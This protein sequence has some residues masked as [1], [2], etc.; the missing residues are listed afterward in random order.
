MRMRW[1]DGLEAPL[2]RYRI[3][4][5]LLGLGVLL[6]VTAVVVGLKLCCAPLP[7]AIVKPLAA[8]DPAVMEEQ[9]LR[10]AVLR[11]A[12]AMSKLNAARAKAVADAVN[13]RSNEA[14]P[15]S[16]LIALNS[17]LALLRQLDE[18]LRQDAVADELAAAAA[19]RGVSAGQM[20]VRNSAKQ[21]LAA[22]VDAKKPPYL[23]LHLD[24]LAPKRAPGKDFIDAQLKVASRAATT[25]QWLS[26]VGS[27]A[28]GQ[29]LNDSHMDAFQ[30]GVIEGKP[31]RFTGKML[32]YNHSLE[33]RYLMS[34]APSP[35]DPRGFILAS[36]TKCPDRVDKTTTEITID[37]LLSTSEA[38][39]RLD[40]GSTT[41]QLPA[42]GACPDFMQ[43]NQGE[44][45]SHGEIALLTTDLL[46]LEIRPFEDS[47]VSVMLILLRE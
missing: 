37:K 2:G 30:Q 34:L 46:L 22:S 9:K 13:A 21:A 40:F 24:K 38:L 31:F 6:V 3:W 4:A 1:R 5:L 20:Y 42:G 32:S 25:G 7:G 17:S 8:E 15:E 33:C 29:G 12:E 11:T 35:S 18:Y 26:E 19:R 45:S 23:T 47:E 14:A 10:D 28:S 27:Q 41:C 39:V 36:L 16:R 43:L 44:E